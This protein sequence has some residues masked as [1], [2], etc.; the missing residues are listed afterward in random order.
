[1][2]Y[3]CFNCEKDFDEPENDMCPHCYS[4]DFIDKAEREE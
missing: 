3:E 1:M 2:R 4:T